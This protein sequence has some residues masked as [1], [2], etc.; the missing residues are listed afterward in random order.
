VVDRVLPLD[1]AA[2]AH[3]LAEKG[4]LLGKIVLAPQERAS[5]GEG[6]GA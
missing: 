4:G 6:A 3:R 1:Q 2:E 5:A